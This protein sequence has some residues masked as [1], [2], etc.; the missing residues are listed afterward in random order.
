MVHG[1]PTLANNRE[2]RR[3]SFVYVELASWRAHTVP[4]QRKRA[5]DFLSR[6]VMR[7]GRDEKT[8]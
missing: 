8:I 3:S 6:D 1:K 4:Q 7:N 5:T 2:K